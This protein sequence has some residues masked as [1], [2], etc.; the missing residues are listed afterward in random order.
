MIKNTYIFSVFIHDRY[1][2]KKYC[3]YIAVSLFPCFQ[4]NQDKNIVMVYISDI[5]ILS[6]HCF[7]VLIV[8]NIH[9][10][11]SLSLLSITIT[12]TLCDLS[13]YAIDINIMF[14]YLSCL[15]LPTFETQNLVDL[16]FFT[17]VLNSLK[18]I[19]QSFYTKRIWYL[20]V[21]WDICRY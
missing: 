9:V 20:R 15:F 18:K 3:I 17:N 4:F 2:L 12:L 16:E 21:V 6:Q 7:N 10:F 5:L 13:K 11:S 1:D 14:C 19:L 8:Q